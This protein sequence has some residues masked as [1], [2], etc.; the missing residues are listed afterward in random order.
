MVVEGVEVV[1][2]GGGE[3]WFLYTQLIVKTSL[4]KQKKSKK[5]KHTLD[6]HLKTCGVVLK[7]F[8]YIQVRIVCDEKEFGNYRSV[9]QGL[10][11]ASTP[12]F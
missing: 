1:V 12:G 9:V 10:D 7:F 8:I 4:L 3:R 11:L 2:V 6:L 5:E